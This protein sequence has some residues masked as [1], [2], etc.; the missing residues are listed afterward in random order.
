M[1]EK[2]LPRIKQTSEQVENS[3]KTLTTA[4]GDRVPQVGMSSRRM[5]ILRKLSDMYCSCWLV[6][7]LF[8]CFFYVVGSR[9]CCCQSVLLMC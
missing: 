2:Y 4:L 5:N 6:L 8:M 1:H 3:P 7:L 9:W